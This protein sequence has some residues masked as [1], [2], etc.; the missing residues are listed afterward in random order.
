[1]PWSP[2][3]KPEADSVADEKAPVRRCYRYLVNR[4]GQFDYKSAIESDLP[5]G[6]G[7]VE[8]AH[9]YVIQERLK[10]TGAWWNPEQAS[11]ML[12]LRTLRANRGW[13]NYWEQAKLKAA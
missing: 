9:R 11:N 13:D 5:I 1:M 12:A 7:E 8:S 4:P 3:W 10:K 2:I 6:S